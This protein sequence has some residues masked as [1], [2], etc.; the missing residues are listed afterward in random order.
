M[1]T[2]FIPVLLVVAASLHGY[3][4]TVINKVIPVKGG[5]KIVMHFDYPQLIKVSTWDKNEIA[6][7]G[8]VSIN[9]GENDNAFILENSE[10]GNVISIRSEIKDM[11][12]LPR[13]YVVTRGEQK[14]VFK[15]KSDFK[16]YQTE[17]PGAYNSL[18]MNV[19]IEIVLEVKVPKN[20]DT[21]VE[22]V[23][24]MVEITDFTGP[25]TVDATYGG[26]D[27]ALQEVSTGE[28]IAETNYGQI[29]TNLNLKFIGNK[30]EDFHTY[31]SAK[32][33]KGPRY[34]F[35]SKYG[36]VYIRKPEAK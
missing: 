15:D 26:V 33:G 27:A 5:Q 25:L 13:R 4:Q 30:E 24:G 7:T 17:N 20:M 11:K 28:L 23:Y 29:Y 19:E 8:K 34:S 16:K 1:K 22:S 14:I 10:S 3:T 12:N 35:E 36:N 6:I 18:S 9:A 2:Q 21:R 31:V 32:P